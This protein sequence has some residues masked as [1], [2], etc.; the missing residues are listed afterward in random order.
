[1][2]TFIREFQF[3]E[4]F[5]IKPL[6]GGVF[7]SMCSR[8]RIECV[9]CTRISNVIFPPQFTQ[10]ENLSKMKT[11]FMMWFCHWENK[12]IE[13]RDKHLEKFAYKSSDNVLHKNTNISETK[14]IIITNRVYYISWK[15]WFYCVLIITC[16]CMCLYTV[17]T[18]YSILKNWIM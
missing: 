1:M 2:Q 16:L 3:Q 4:P 14:I 5:H 18:L 13:N 10:S 7:G 15:K 9:C 8:I 17:P 11:F 6:I 12:C